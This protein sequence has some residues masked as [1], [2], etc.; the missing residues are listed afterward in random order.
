VELAV[1]NVYEGYPEIKNKKKTSGRGRKFTAVKVAT[2]SCP[3]YSHF[4]LLLHIKTEMAGQKFNE[5]R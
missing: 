4:H 5:E 2:L 3:A 1:T